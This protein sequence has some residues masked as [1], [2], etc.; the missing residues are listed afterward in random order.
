M[1]SR[2]R[3]RCGN[4]DLTAFDV[5]YRN[6]STWVTVPGGSITNNN[7]VWKKLT[8]TAVTTAKIRVV[9]NAA[10]DGVARI[11]EVEAWTVGSGSS[12]NVHWLVTDQLGTPRMVFDRTGSLAGV[13]RHD[14]LPFGEGLYAGT[15]GRTT[16]Q[17]Y[18]ASD[19]VRQKFTSKEK[20]NET[21]LDYFEARYYASTQGRF[22][23]RDPYNILLE[24]QFATDAKKAQSQF[25]TY[26]SDPQ[27]WARYTY[28]LNN[29][30][31]YTDPSGED[32]TIYYRA[33]SD[34]RKLGPLP[35][36]GHFFI[37]VK[38]DE[39]GESAYF[40]YW[41]NP[42]T[43]ET[44]LGQV[45][46]QRLS[47]HASLTIETTPQQEQ[48]ILGGIKEMQNSAPNYVLTPI[49]RRSG[50]GNVSECTNN[51]INLLQ[52]GGIGVGFI[53]KFF[54][55]DAWRSLFMQYAPDQTKIVR[56]YT[57][58]ERGPQWHDDVIIPDQKGGRYG[59]D[60]RGQARHVDPKALNNR[61]L[62]FRDGKRLN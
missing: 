54:P 27:R 16:A 15:G 7:L 56:K 42:D 36:Q 35:D 23:S 32:V 53:N 60:P 45:D 47:E 17:G 1:L 12:A 61:E 62:R 18:S 50:I 58:S 48:A 33:P 4:Y 14:Y 43:G 51:S 59:R 10:V 20:D 24:T 55:G 37:Y 26:L 31:L 49:G 57:G 19:G 40:D 28:A 46:D 25:V 29:P 21:G 2:V 8:F 6:G 5:Q 41:V 44:V 52:R 11:C 34:D 38:N 39:T 30:L 22:T 13:S 9:V 3:V